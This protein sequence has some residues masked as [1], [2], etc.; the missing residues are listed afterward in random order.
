MRFVNADYFVHR[1]IEKTTEV[2]QRHWKKL[3]G[4]NPSFFSKH[5]ED[6]PVENVS[7][8]DVQEFIEELNQIDTSSTYR[9][10]T[11]AE[12]E[13]ACRAGSSKAFSNGIIT[14]LECHEN[15]SLNQIGW[16]N[17]NSDNKTHP[18]GLKKPNPLG[19]YDMHGNVNEWCQDSFVK[20]YS[21]IADSKNYI[22]IETEDKVARSCSWNDT[23]VSCRA[24]SK[25]NFTPDKKSNTIGFRLVR[26]PK[27]Y[28][29]ITKNPIP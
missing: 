15:S 23:A 11:E 28:K 13:F 7:W 6:C 1:L 27:Y 21:N 25:K 14:N 3:M 9:L 20:Y 4:N 16:Y 26:E 29:A 2:T 18:V 17:C 12:W 24:A 10:P 5:C 22:T 8:F 19:I